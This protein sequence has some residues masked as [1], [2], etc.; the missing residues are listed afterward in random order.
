MS[1]ALLRSAS[2]PAV[3][4]TTSDFVAAVDGAP[5]QPVTIPTTPAPR[6]ARPTATTTGQRPARA[7]TDEYLRQIAQ[8]IARLES[9]LT[10]QVSTIATRVETV[11][12]ENRATTDGAQQSGY[13]VNQELWTAETLDN[14]RNGVTVLFKRPL[15]S[16]V[17]EIL[18]LNRMWQ[19]PSPVP[20]RITR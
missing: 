14:S 3:D 11:A 9:R 6:P 5:V 2:R 10:A 7:S 15:R 4:P 16:T 17:N 1:P 8:T 13:L 12:Q 18:R 20:A 19:A